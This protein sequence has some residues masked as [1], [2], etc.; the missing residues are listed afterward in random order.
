MKGVKGE[1]AMSTRVAQEESM[2]TGL[3]QR[4]AMVSGR[5]VLQV[6]MAMPSVEKLG[7]R[8]FEEPAA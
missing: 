7:R 5:N 3:H 6:A 4:D 1:N 2:V 8:T